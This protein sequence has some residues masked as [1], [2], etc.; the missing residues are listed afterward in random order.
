MSVIEAR[1]A[2]S[3][4][5]TWRS[6]R[7][8]LDQLDGRFDLALDEIRANRDRDRCQRMIDLAPAGLHLVEPFRILFLG[9][10]NVGK[11]RLVNALVGHERAIVSNRE[12]TTRDLLTTRS[13]WDG[14]PIE[15]WDGAGFRETDDEIERAGQQMLRKRR[16]E[17][18]LGALVIDLSRRQPDLENRLRVE[19]EPAIVVGNK[20]DLVEWNDGVADPAPD[21]WV[22]SLSG[23]GLEEL[24]SMIMHRLVPF[25]PD[26]GEPLP[27]NRRQIELLRALRESL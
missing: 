25:Q 26:A 18:D 1:R 21:V 16:R 22:S 10:T 27:I 5:P 19:L 24:M 12:G 23:A 4:A 9:P 6:A 2:L 13:A 11:S 8:L 20:S 14:W 17:A 15:F 3:N 7:L